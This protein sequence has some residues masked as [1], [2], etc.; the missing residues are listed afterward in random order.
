MHLH[1]FNEGFASRDTNYQQLCV[2]VSA[3][4]SSSVSVTEKISGH[5]NKRRMIDNKD[6]K[7]MKMSLQKTASA[8]CCAP[9]EVD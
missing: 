9:L 2:K 1:N 8:P 5:G 4:S 3:P 7:K 6:T